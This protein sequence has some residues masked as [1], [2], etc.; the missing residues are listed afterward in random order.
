[1]EQLPNYNIIILPTEDEPILGTILYRKAFDCISLWRYKETHVYA[2]GTKVYR[3][4]GGSFEDW[5]SCMKPHHVYVT[6]DDEIKEGDWITGT[7]KDWGIYNE[8]HQVKVVKNLESGK[9]FWFNEECNGI[10]AIPEQSKKVVSSTDKSLN[11][12]QPSEE[13]I[14]KYIEDYNKEFKKDYFTFEKSIKEK[15][16]LALLQ[17]L[18]YSDNEFIIQDGVILNINE[19]LSKL[20]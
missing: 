5:Y 13:L 19:E 12:H 17:L 4:L 8:V 11:L 1:M 20:L 16:R 15:Y 14:K 9:L 6:S 2:D 10:G 3:T 18:E 7:E